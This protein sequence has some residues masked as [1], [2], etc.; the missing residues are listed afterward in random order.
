MWLCKPSSQTSI[1]SFYYI[2]PNSSPSENN[3]GT[4]RL[5]QLTMAQT[6]PVN[7]ESLANLL[8]QLGLLEMVKAHPKSAALIFVVPKS[9]AAGFELQPIELEELT[10]WTKVLLEEE[11]QA[12]TMLVENISFN[13]LRKLHFKHDEKQKLAELKR[14]LEAIPQFVKGVKG[15]E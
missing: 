4:L 1:D 5:F 12:T 9:K 6:H 7:G 3:C 2:K 11:A 14:T 8:K 15:L 10:D 13:T